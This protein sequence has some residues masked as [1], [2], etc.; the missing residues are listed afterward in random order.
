MLSLSTASLG[1]APAAPVALTQTRAPAPV[2]ETVED[3]KALAVKLNPSIGYWC[4]PSC[5]V[6]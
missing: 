2:M 1:F 5:C 6:A 3:L 4:A